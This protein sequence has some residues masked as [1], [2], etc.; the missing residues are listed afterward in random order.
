MEEPGAEDVAPCCGGQCRVNKGIRA[1]ESPSP[2]GE[3]SKLKGKNKTKREKSEHFAPLGKG[4][5]SREGLREGPAAWIKTQK[6]ARRKFY[7][8]TRHVGTKFTI[9]Q[10]QRRVWTP[11]KG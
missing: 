11:S 3:K 1:T 8:D 2:R 4:V 5:L 9:V 6:K 10:G 7:R